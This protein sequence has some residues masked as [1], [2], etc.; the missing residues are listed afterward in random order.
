MQQS[1]GQ[2]LSQCD[3]PYLSEAAALA[4]RLLDQQMSGAQLQSFLHRQNDRVIELLQTMHRELRAQGQISRSSELLGPRV[5]AEL[6]QH[7]I[8][9]LQ[10]SF[11]QPHDLHKGLGLLHAYVQSYLQQLQIC[12]EPHPDAN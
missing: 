3:L 10:D 11:E 8:Q 9:Q 1:R 12:T 4:L 2:P 7:I 6:Q 5:M